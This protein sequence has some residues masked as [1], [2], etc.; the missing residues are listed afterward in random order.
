MN[1]DDRLRKIE[2]NLIERKEFI[3]LCEKVNETNTG[4]VRIMAIMEERAKH[5]RN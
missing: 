5:E 2:A 3:A 1:I 4:V